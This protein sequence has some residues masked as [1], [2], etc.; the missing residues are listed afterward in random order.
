V[1]GTPLVLV[2][3]ETAAITVINRLPEATTVH[4]HGMELE[5]VYDGVAGW[6]RTGDHTAV[7]GGAAS[8]P[9]ELRAGIRYRLRL[10][11]ILSAPVLRVLTFQADR[12]SIQQVIRVRP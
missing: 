11:N 7:N 1:P 9:I 12:E 4:W 8:K 3:G 10:A 6:S 5:S 2:R